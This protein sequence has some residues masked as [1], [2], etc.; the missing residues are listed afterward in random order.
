MIE[1]LIVFLTIACVVMVVWQPGFIGKYL[2]EKKRE[3][4]IQFFLHEINKVTKDKIMIKAIVAVHVFSDS[5]WT[6]D[7]SHQ[8]LKSFIDSL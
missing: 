1:P 7:F 2:R 4:D 8:Q 5:A 6:K 3:H